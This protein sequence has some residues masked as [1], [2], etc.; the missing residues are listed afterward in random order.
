MTS[1]E[2]IYFYCNLELQ[3]ERQSIKMWYITRDIF[4]GTYSEITHTSIFFFY[5][6]KFLTRLSVDL[7]LARNFSYSYCFSTFSPF[8]TRFR[9]AS[10][11]F[12][13]AFLDIS[14]S[15][16]F[17][18]HLLRV[19]CSR[20]FSSAFLRRHSSSFL[21]CLLTRLLSVF[22]A[23]P[24]TFFFI[25][26]S[27][28]PPHCRSFVTLNLRFFPF[29]IFFTGRFFNNSNHLFLITYNFW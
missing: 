28:F 22:S 17:P 14:S 3:I 20:G 1:W 6:P 4:D 5:S 18:L 29:L 16:Y 12:L 7:H 11:S 21:P 8:L 26:A 23:A 19:A 2:Q 24:I 13:T 15:F 25:L 9:Y 10:L 27:E